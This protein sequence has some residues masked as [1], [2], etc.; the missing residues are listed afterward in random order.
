MTIWILLLIIFIV[1]TIVSFILV[2]IYDL[3]WCI[4]SGTI[5]LFCIGISLILVIVQPIKLNQ[6][7][8]RML[9]EKQQI[10]YQIE[11]L[12]Q[13]KDKIKLNEWILDYND[14]VNDV[15]AEKES[16]GWFAWHW[17][18]DMSEFEIIDLV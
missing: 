17:N 15:N 3:D 5:G 6:E 12:T 8:N 16:Y 13:D 7:R 11:H 9:K 4:S 10:E 2:K 14:W 18:F 1:I